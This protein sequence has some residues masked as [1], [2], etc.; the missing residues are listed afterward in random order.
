[1]TADIGQELARR[2]ERLIGARVESYTRVT[3]GYTPAT[4]L[5]CRTSTATFF[6]KIGATPRTSQFVRREMHI[7]NAVSG[8]FMPR[9]V[10]SEDHESAPVLILEDLSAARWPPPWDE[11]RVE[12]VL[13]RIDEMH[14]TPVSLEPR[15]DAHG[16]PSSNWQTVAAGP[17]P[18]LALG[19]ADAR[20]L[21]GAL[22]ILLRHE[23]QCRTDGESLTHCDLRSDNMCMNERGALFVD[24]N[25]A[26]LSNPALDLGFWLPSLAFE[27]GPGP[28]RILPDAPDVA[29]WVSGF[30]AARAGLPVIP[31]MPR[32]RL[33]QRQQL[34]M[35]LPWAARALDLSPPGV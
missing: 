34:Q 10:A 5:L 15:A 4:R 1:M 29:A 8:A 33:V 35:A 11:R 24:W 26:C 2:I 22:P 19:L 18:F 20:W 14:H 32:V 12:L 23:A 13:A 6:A 27:G 25:L 7:Y 21:D 17:E 30:F 16:A 9:L 3:G 28:E 31:E